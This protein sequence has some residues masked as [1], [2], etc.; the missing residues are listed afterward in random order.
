[1]QEQCRSYQ[2]HAQANN[3]SVAASE[4]DAEL[5]IVPNSYYHH[6]GFTGGNKLRPFVPAHLA[7]HHLLCTP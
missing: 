1:M 2:A 3:L 6:G 5:D 7:F 4:R